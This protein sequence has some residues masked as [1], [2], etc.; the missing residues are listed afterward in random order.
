MQTYEYVRPDP[1]SITVAYAG[2]VYGADVGSRIW[3]LCVWSGE[4]SVEM[5]WRGGHPEAML[6]ILEA[7]DR[8]FLNISLAPDA[9]LRVDART[10]R[11]TFCQPEGRLTW[12]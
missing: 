9:W 2:R 8:S 7:P 4:G 5:T 6:R 3:V 11:V 12:P 1:T 10:R